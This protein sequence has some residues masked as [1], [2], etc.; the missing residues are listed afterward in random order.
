MK[1][2]EG[3]LA[4]DN[5]SQ[6]IQEPVVIDISRIEILASAIYTWHPSVPGQ[7]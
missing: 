2:H 4:V 7:I 5:Q 1:S 3:L 6:T